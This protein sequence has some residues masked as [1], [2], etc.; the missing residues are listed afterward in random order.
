[1]DFGY[2]KL[3][4]KGQL[5]DSSSQ[6]RKEV[7]CPGTEEKVAEIAWASKEDALIALESAREGFEYWSALPLEK[8]AQWMLRLR[9]AVIEKAEYLR[10]AIMYE[11]GKP[12]E[13]TEED[14]ET[15]INALAWYPEEMKRTRDE[16]LPDIQN[17]HSHKII[18]QPAGVAVAFLA[19]NFPLLNIGFKL[20]PA[21][22]AGCSLIIR[23]SASSPLSAY[24]LGE[25]L[26]EIDFPKGVVNILCG[27]SNEV[28]VTLSQSKIPKVLTMIGSSET[29]RKLI[30]QS[31]TSIKRMS[32]ELGGNAPVLV[33]EDADLEKAV[34][35]VAALKFG[36]CG[37]ICVAP[38]RIFI[39]ENVFDDFEKLFV[40]Q[41]EKIKIGFGRENNPTMGPL[42]NAEARDRIISMVKDALD[43]GA[44]LLYGGKIPSGFQ[45]GYFYEPTVLEN[46]SVDMRVFKEE[47]FGPVAPLISFSDEEEV[48]KA[49]NDTE[50]GLASYLYTKD[51]NRIQRISRALQFGEVH[52]NGFKYAIDLPHGG[53]KESGIGHDCSHLALE[54]YLVKKRVTIKL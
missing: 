35:E 17:T 52:V 15:V 29:G 53:I 44:E 48:I 42:I 5:K 2:K 28:A 14:Y 50:Y 41:A 47:I 20:G 33:F 32:M 23:P 37:Q 40:H 54:D 45:K 25:I 49:A 13:A 43:K 26:K 10:S 24:V 22:A 18:R 38:N 16:I 36:N 31:A 12:W 19:W 30:T 7:F 8:R 3:Y 46:I 9:E 1:M 39:H 51:V 34:A 21:L 27:S 4:I 6:T 11:M